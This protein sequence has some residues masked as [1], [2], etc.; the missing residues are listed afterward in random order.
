MDANTKTGS[1][2]QSQWNQPINC[3]L[4][5]PVKGFSRS[6][7]LTFDP[8]PSNHVQTLAASSG[9]GGRGFTSIW[10]GCF[11]E[12]LVTRLA[13]K[14]LRGSDSSVKWQTVYQRAT[15]Y[16]TQH[17]NKMTGYFSHFTW[18]AF[19][20]ILIQL[21]QLSKNLK[22]KSLCFIGNLDS[23]APPTYS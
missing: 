4:S 7:S 19:L 1:E 15:F 14:S 18:V 3:S 21:L 6:D 16:S 23:L 9:G 12:E 10:P 2:Q 8:L 17:L 11:V 13:V 22:P 5:Q 20:K